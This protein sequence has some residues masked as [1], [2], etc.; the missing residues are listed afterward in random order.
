[1]ISTEARLG[2]DITNVIA[3]LHSAF[4]Q[5]PELKS[6]QENETSPLNLETR[7]S[8]FRTAENRAW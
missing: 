8:A 5:T 6:K 3:V 4:S 1:L 2:E 7:G